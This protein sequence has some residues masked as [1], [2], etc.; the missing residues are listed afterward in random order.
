MSE[1]KKTYEELVQECAE[2]RRDLDVVLHPIFGSLKKAFEVAWGSLG[3][4]K[5]DFKRLSDLVYYQGGY[6]QPDSLPKEVVLA[7]TVA[8]ALELEKYLGR[9]ILR[10]LLEDRGIT[11]TFTDEVIPKG[12][13]GDLNDKEEASLKDGWAGAGLDG[14]VPNDRFEVLKRLIDRAQTLQKEIC[15]TADTIKVDA[16]EVAES[17]HK[18]AKGNFVKAV[19][20]AAIKLRRGEGPMLEKIEAIH[21]AQENMNQALEPLEKIEK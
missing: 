4:T 3:Y 19:G 2:I 16:A 12:F 18:I 14:E 6:P 13:I 8:K 5:S 7:D 20:L 17:E 9:N 11:I 21:D 10:L 1:D 15:E